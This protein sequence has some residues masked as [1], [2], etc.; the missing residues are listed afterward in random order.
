MQRIDKVKVDAL[1]RYA[2]F[3]GAVIVLVHVLL[4][5]AIVAVL[6]VAVVLQHGLLFVGRVHVACFG[7]LGELTAKVVGLLLLHPVT[8]TLGI[9]STPA[10][11]VWNV[12]VMNANSKGMS[13]SETWASNIHCT[14]IIR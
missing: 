12:D 9:S 11:A 14:G 10:R 13:S 8:G 7:L 1:I 2:Q 6:A 5:T 4:A 3:G